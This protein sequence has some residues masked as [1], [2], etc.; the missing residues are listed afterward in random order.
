MSHATIDQSGLNRGGLHLYPQGNQAMFDN[1]ASVL[2][3]KSS[4]SPISLDAECAP[5]PIVI[6]DV[7]SN[8]WIIPSGR[9]FKVAALNVNNLLAHIDEIRILLAENPLDILTIKETK[10]KVPNSNNEVYVP[11]YEIVRHDRLSDG[12]G[13]ICFYI[14]TSVNFSI[15]LIYICKIPDCAF[16]RCHLIQSP[17]HASWY[18][19]SFSTF[20]W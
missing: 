15:E 4:W 16:S 20:C 11:G 14:R 19:Q 3:D 5:S 9:G 6:G 8:Y 2:G 17:W 12:G 1:F 10:L 7:D 18:F 13:G